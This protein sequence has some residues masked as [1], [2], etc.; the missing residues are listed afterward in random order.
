M[1][2]RFLSYQIILDGG[3]I[4]VS[5]FQSMDLGEEPQVPL[6]SI[7]DTKESWPIVC[8]FVQALERSGLA[9][10]KERP[11]EIGDG[12]KNSWLIE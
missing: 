9:S 6:F 10:L 5:T 7:G 1:S 4:F 2:G 8:Q 12:G 3:W 11:I